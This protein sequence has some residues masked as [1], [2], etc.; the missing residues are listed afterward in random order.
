[1]DVKPVKEVAVK[2][3]VVDIYEEGKV[4]VKGVHTDKEIAAAGVLTASANQASLDNGG[5]DE[6]EL[7]TEE[8]IAQAENVAN[9]LREVCLR[10]QIKSNRNLKITSLM[11]IS[12]IALV[13]FS[14]VGAEFL[15]PFISSLQLVFIS[16]VVWIFLD[17]LKDSRK[18]NKLSKELEALNSRVEQMRAWYGQEESRSQEEL[19]LKPEYELVPVEG[20]SFQQFKDKHK[21]FVI[22][23]IIASM[24][25]IVAVS[26]CE[27]SKLEKKADKVG[28]NSDEAHAL[29]IYWR[30]IAEA[31]KILS[32]FRHTR[33]EGLVKMVFQTPYSYA[34]GDALQALANVNPQKAG[35]LA[36]AWAKEG[37]AEKE[38]LD[39]C[40]EAI[41]S[42][43]FEQ[44]RKKPEEIDPELK[45]ILELAGI[46]PQS[47]IVG[48]DREDIFRH[49]ELKH[50][51][52]EV[53]EVL[54]Q[55]KDRA[56]LP[57]MQRLIG[58][59]YNQDNI[60][61]ASLAISFGSP[62]LIPDLKATLESID[63]HFDKLVRERNYDL[64]DSDSWASGGLFG[65]R[66]AQIALA[67]AIAL[68]GDKDYVTPKL[69]E[70]LEFHLKLEE[71]G[72]SRFDTD[73]S[74]PPIHR[75]AGILIRLGEAE[76]VVP[77]LWDFYNVLEGLREYAAGYWDTHSLAEL[78][79]IAKDKDAPSLV[80]K[81]WTRA[82][83]D[84]SMHAWWTGLL[85]A[86]KRLSLTS[87]F[88]NQKLAEW[89]ENESVQNSSDASDVAKTLVSLRDEE[90]IDYFMRNLA[91]PLTDVS[92]LRYNL[93]LR[94]GAAKALI[95][96][97]R[98]DRDVKASLDNGGNAS[99]TSLRIKAAE[100]LGRLPLDKNETVQIKLD[101]A[102][103]AIMQNKDLLRNWLLKWAKYNGIKGI[104]GVE[105]GVY[106]QEQYLRIK[107]GGDY[108]FSLNYVHNQSDLTILGQDVSKEHKGKGLMTLMQ[109]FLFYVFNLS[110]VSYDNLRWDGHR[111]VAHMA[112]K[113]V[114]AYKLHH[115]DG[116][117]E[118]DA[119][120]EVN[121]ARVREYIL[122]ERFAEE[123]IGCGGEGRGQNV[124]LDNGGR[125]KVLMLFEGSSDE[126]NAAVKMLEG[127]DAVSARR[128]VDEIVKRTKDLSGETYAL[129]VWLEGLASAGKE[130][131]PFLQKAMGTIVSDPRKRDKSYLELRYWAIS[132][133]QKIGLLE[134][135]RWTVG[136]LRDIYLKRGYLAING[137]VSAVRETTF[138]SNYE[139][140]SDD[141][142][143]MNVP[144]FMWEK[145]RQT[146]ILVISSQG[147]TKDPEGNTNLL[148]LL[149]KSFTSETKK[150]IK[151]IK[152]E[153]E[154][155]VGYQRIDDWKQRFSLDEARE[156]G[157][158]IFPK[159]DSGKSKIINPAG[160]LD[161]GGFLRN[162]YKYPIKN[163]NS[164]HVSRSFTV[165]PG[166]IFHSGRK[167]EIIICEVNYARGVIILN[168][169][170]PNQ[171]FIEGKGPRGPPAKTQVKTI[172][173]DN[174]PREMMPGLNIQIQRIKGN[175][176]NIRLI[177]PQSRPFMKGPVPILNK[178]FNVKASLDNGG[179]ASQANLR[180]K[181][182]ESLGRLPLDKNETI[183]IPAL[184]AML[185]VE[186][187]Q[188]VWVSSE[189]ATAYPQFLPAVPFQGFFGNV[190][191]EE[192]QQMLY[193]M[194]SGLCASINRF[195]A[196]NIK[197]GEHKV[198]F[199]ETAFSANAPPVI[200]ADK[201]EADYSIYFSPA[202]RKIIEDLT[203]RI[204]FQLKEKIEEA[205][206]LSIILLAIVVHE[207][208]EMTGLIH[209]QA[210][211]SQRKVAHYSIVAEGLESLQAQYSKR[212][213]LRAEV[214]EPSN[215]QAKAIESAM[216]LL[217]RVLMSLGSKPEYNEFT[218]IE[219]YLKYTP[220]K[221]RSDNN[222][223][224]LNSIIELPNII[225]GKS[226]A[227]IC[228][229]LIIAGAIH[230]YHTQGQRVMKQKAEN[231]VRIANAEH[232]SP[233]N[234]QF[235][236]SILDVLGVDGAWVEEQAKTARQRKDKETERGLNEPEAKLDN[237]LVKK[238]L[239][240]KR[241]NNGDMEQ[242]WRLYVDELNKALSIKGADFLAGLLESL[243]G[244]YYSVYYSSEFR[245]KTETI[246]K[247]GFYVLVATPA[248][249]SLGQALIRYLN[250]PYPGREGEVSGQ[251]TL[252]GAAERISPTRL[253]GNLS[254]TPAVSILIEELRKGK[255]SKVVAQRIQEQEQAG[256]VSEAGGVMRQ[257]VGGPLNTSG[258][259]GLLSDETGRPLLSGPEGSIRNKAEK[260]E[261]AGVYIPK[262]APEAGY[263]LGGAVSCEEL[264]EALAGAKSFDEFMGNLYLSAK[265]IFGNTS[266]ALTRKNNK[267]EEGVGE[268]SEWFR[269]LHYLTGRPRV[270]KVFNS[271][272]RREYKDLPKVAKP[273]NVSLNELESVILFSL[274]LHAYL[275]AKG[276]SR[277][278][279]SA[280]S[281][282][283][284]ALHEQVGLGIFKAI[285]NFYSSFSRVAERSNELKKDAEAEVSGRQAAFAEKAIGQRTPQAPA[286]GTS[287]RAGS[288]TPERKEQREKEVIEPSFANFTKRIREA[289]LDDKAVLILNGQPADARKK[290]F[291]LFAG[292][293]AEFDSYAQWFRAIMTATHPDTCAH[294]LIELDPFSQYQEKVKELVA[295]V[296]KLFNVLKELSEAEIAKINL[297][298]NK[299][300]KLGGRL[301]I[302]K[303][304]IPENLTILDVAR[305]FADRISILKQEQTKLEGRINEL[306]GRVD[307]LDN[308]F[309]GKAPKLDSGSSQAAAANEKPLDNGGK[310]KIAVFEV[311]ESKIYIGVLMMLSCA[312]MIA[313]KPFLA[314]ELYKDTALNAWIVQA[315]Y[316]L[317]AFIALLIYKIP[318][319]TKHFKERS[320]RKFLPQL[321]KSEKLT[322]FFSII[323]GQI[324]AS[325]LAY[326]ALEHN[327]ALATE[328]IIKTSPILVAILAVPIL[329]EKINFIK[330]LGILFTFTGGLTVV[331][332]LKG[333]GDMTFLGIIF[334]VFSSFAYAGSEIVKKKTRSFKNKLNTSSLLLFSYLAAFPIIA[335][336]AQFMS[337]GFVLII[338]PCIFGIVAISLATLLLSYKSLDYLKT[339]VSKSINNTSP[340]FVL[341]IS[342]TVF[343]LPF[344]GY[345]AMLGVMLTV[346][347]VVFVSGMNNGKKH[348]NLISTE[349][350]EFPNKAGRKERFYE[351]TE[352][353]R[354]LKAVTDKLEPFGLLELIG[355]IDE[356]NDP[357][358]KEIICREDSLKAIFRN[359]AESGKVN[360]SKVVNF[361]G[362]LTAENAQ[363]EID[364]LKEEKRGALDNGG[365]KKEATKAGVIAS[366]P[367]VFSGQVGDEFRN[368]LSIWDSIFKNEGPKALI[369]EILS[370]PE[371]KRQ[372]SGI[373]RLQDRG[374]DASVFVNRQ[375]A[376]DFKSERLRLSA[377]ALRGR[378][379]FILQMEY[380]LSQAFLEAFY[381]HLVHI[382]NCGR[383]DAV[384]NA[385]Q[386]AKLLMAGGLGSFKPDLVQGWYDVLSKHW[387][388]LEARNRLHVMGVLYA[389]A[390]KGQYKNRGFPCLRGPLAG[391]DIL[392]S[393][394]INR[395]SPDNGLLE[396]VDS[397]EIT[398]R[399]CDVDTVHVELYRNPFSSLKEYWLYCPEIF[400]EAYPGNT[401]DYWRAIQT[402]VYRRV[403]LEFIKRGQQARKTFNEGSPSIRPSYFVGDKLIFSLSEVN[404][405]LVVPEV[406]EA[407]RDGNGGIIKGDG[408]GD[409]EGFKD[410]LIHHYNHTI[411]PAGMPYYKEYMLEALSI[412]K[413]FRK[414]ARGGKV[415]LVKITGMVSDFITGCSSLHTRILRE[416]IFREFSAKVVEDDLFGNSEGSY[417]K[418]WQGKQIQAVLKRYMAKVGIVGN[419]DVFF[420]V[421]NDPKHQG[422]RSD[423]IKELLEAKG[424][425]KSSFIDSLLEGTFGEVLV[426]RQ[427]FEA[428][429]LNIEAMPFFGFVRRLVDYK[430]CDFIID[431]LY[432]EKAR[433]VIKE[434]KAIIIL[435]GRPFDGWAHE[436][437]S[438]VKRLIKD[439]DPEMKFHVF[440][441][442]DHNVFTSWLIQQAV[443]FGGMLSWK[444]KEAGPTSFSNAQQNLAPVFATLDGVIPERMVNVVR[445]KQGF[446]V[447]GTG[448]I[449]DYEEKPNGDGQIKPKKQSFMK[450]LAAACQDYH[451]G[452]AYAAVA[453]DSL[454]MGLTQG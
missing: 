181:A 166:D 261:V 100:S 268:L 435:G 251:H 340:I 363:E 19:S 335:M 36:K 164:Q 269:Y 204:S 174:R 319:I 339:S 260:V 132:A 417:I 241:S 389:S 402:L 197:V 214:S 328:T 390:I 13:L 75:I 84:K 18:R 199:Y 136:F 432:D 153:F 108:I 109:I 128:I 106:K 361:I 32:Y 90:G 87:S 428:A 110:S 92:N 394:I 17:F 14:A 65:E 152:E 306:S 393:V 101:L 409:Y 450:Q 157:I 170:R 441:I 163:N 354:L 377:E 242:S 79:I 446:P 370:E 217:G 333:G 244:A 401:D 378:D 280:F 274:I 104:L 24:E 426:T 158:W 452:K 112:R 143:V 353:L 150:E 255:V 278:T 310:N 77:K 342:M 11:A 449:V 155:Y 49:V 127:V 194:T 249:K 314:K 258:F 61:G 39:A 73:Y 362:K 413:K 433:K 320:A 91:E 352:L 344:P 71:R 317:Y 346:I 395:E 316:Y 356:I 211:Y 47:E 111:F 88:L 225:F 257:L 349:N 376:E 347:G 38:I 28:L 318:S 201:R 345:I 443:D 141:S 384:H 107:S 48:Q 117:P 151:K 42:D 235:E 290:L 411:V 30:D 323:F 116:C 208:A 445:D 254:D 187:G 228:N 419:Y 256:K 31:A 21:K 196:F 264:T 3:S 54:V 51:S 33:V 89:Q 330:I 414:A 425:Q 80:K 292:K 300:E 276:S 5:Q 368:R 289:N 67:R 337:D 227:A 63:A 195:D 307:K 57:M 379:I 439:I 118:I 423:F 448:Y 85:P 53:V 200:F 182:V 105:A 286:S 58:A 418:R 250:S 62:E 185:A 122:S 27:I 41:F 66:T 311:T 444:G 135:E 134:A 293:D 233:G 169:E 327:S 10:D 383:S 114:Y 44:W 403:V 59:T 263:K 130:A 294:T 64:D 55:I 224:A 270:L 248:A 371:M 253:Y 140:I 329:K 302:I 137:G 421:L 273:L 149:A 226:T 93:S 275:E 369:E 277:E 243:L 267:T 399:A 238:L 35:I 203:K 160:F 454:R 15:G 74:R 392:E 68:L 97:L 37:E 391:K 207:R 183:A 357:K 324:L 146:P 83:A 34:K 351:G 358:V 266:L 355:A 325:P 420:D 56:A 189:L 272:L 40:V 298:E 237:N 96:A 131:I 407:V 192:K 236:D 176:A 25:E 321:A 167:V 220:K 212:S 416:D 259:A 412:N 262:L 288:F 451:D 322:V 372:V 148:A 386:F 387:G 125:D 156:N 98:L 213:D 410:L 382:C 165:R 6:E 442:D 309:L 453:F 229:T 215:E 247:G 205:K 440:F 133:L 78:L 121:Q 308:Q 381:E 188:A 186:I 45:P 16:W 159:A 29:D 246:A 123:L 404:T 427:E 99:Q 397:F 60:D 326:L 43:E 415:D 438:R 296:H 398:V 408:Y 9:K 23:E 301:R 406:I 291:P 287:A 230:L 129:R 2:E 69:K 145:I 422:L 295:K 86:L 216:C 124:S 223:K 350:I 437:R 120:A 281:L 430:C 388:Y 184:E 313:F 218:K 284:R 26:M 299:D 429:G 102:V 245:I 191:R 385:G 447:W 359:F 285:D 210:V 72:R 234:E 113:G 231:L 94:F 162:N 7:N 279:F 22:P 190:S 193:A 173:A 431:I 81:L 168:L 283:L 396:F 12:G 332:V 365:E 142:I 366:G 171:E 297:A 360:V 434:Q 198:N 70:W 50:I 265:T 209:Q 380:E 179:S 82:A 222:I 405:T 52:S 103:T 95:K 8:I 400:N 331:S 305:F 374:N 221:I 175:K 282:S 436:Q 178:L 126:Q 115:Y 172:P 375:W 364:S 154:V 202:A 144:F 367:F 20:L 336:L 139:E 373:I 334:A 177:S 138:D 46:D 338:N 312:M 315:N 252:I 219:G 161:N 341:L 343:G 271:V 239:Q 147:I 303:G 240:H 76:Y 304:L 232:I 424:N 119:Y 348:N 206:I 4:S 1:P 180:I